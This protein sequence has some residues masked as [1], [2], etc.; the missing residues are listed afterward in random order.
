MLE[1][2][3]Q[4]V[5]HMYEWMNELTNDRMSEWIHSVHIETK[6]KLI[7]A[8]EYSFHATTSFS[9]TISKSARDITAELI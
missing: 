3:S 6:S 4:H 1:H 9:G 7:L 2:K 8:D 5:I